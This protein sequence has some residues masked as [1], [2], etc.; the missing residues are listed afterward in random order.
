MELHMMTDKQ[1]AHIFDGFQDTRNDL[2]ALQERLSRIAYH[3]TVE[4]AEIALG[5]MIHVSR[6]ITLLDT[7]FGTVSQPRIPAPQEVGHA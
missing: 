7:H 4:K 5:I 6:C 1:V 2:A 3:G